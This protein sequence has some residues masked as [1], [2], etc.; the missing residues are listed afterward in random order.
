MWAGKICECGHTQEKHYNPVFFNFSKCSFYSWHHIN[1]CTCSEFRQSLESVLIRMRKK[2]KRQ[3]WRLEC[4]KWRLKND[5]V[6]R[7]S[8]GQDLQ[9]THQAYKEI[10]SIEEEES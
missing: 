2:Q 9:I 6:Y 4:R 1:R 3:S 8:N 5:R 10:S 7:P